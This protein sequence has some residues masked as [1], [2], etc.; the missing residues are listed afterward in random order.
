LRI[1]QSW[2]AL[3]RKP[4]PTAEEAFDDNAE[5]R[6]TAQDKSDKSH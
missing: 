4:T 5:A 1:A 3:I 6:G 2:L